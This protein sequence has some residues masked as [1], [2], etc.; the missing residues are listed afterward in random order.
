MIYSQKINFLELKQLAIN[1]SET[2]K[3]N[4]KLCIGY[5]F[6]MLEKETTF[7]LN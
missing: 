1:F 5:I 7:K 4:L 3:Q 6:E 2:S